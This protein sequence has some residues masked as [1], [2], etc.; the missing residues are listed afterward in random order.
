M[1]NTGTP[2][3][4]MIVEMDLNSSKFTKSL[5]QVKRSLKNSESQMKAQMAVFDSS[6][7]KLGK[8][9]S[10][11]NGLNRSL[12][13]NQ[14]H[15]DNLTKAY[16]EEVAVNGEA[17]VRAQNLA[18]D[19]NNSVA[20]QAMLEKQLKATGAAM[21]VEKLNIEELNNKMQ[22]NT[23][24]TDAAAQK[25][26]LAG[27][28]MGAL[29]TQYAGLGQK[30]NDLTRIRE[31]ERQKLEVIAQ[32]SG[33]T[34]SAYINQKA[35]LVELDN[36]I[37]TSITKM[38]NYGKQIGGLS[39]RFDNMRNSLA[40]TATKF[41]E[42]GDKAWESGKNVSMRFS[43]PLAAGIGATIKAAANFETA[44]TGVKKTVDEVVDRNGKVTYSY[45]TLETGIRQMAKEI[46]ASTTEISAVAEA[47]GQLGIQ[48][49]NVLGFT[50][51]MINMGVS[52]NMSSE[53]AAT[54][55]ARLANI[56]QMSQKDFDKLGSVIV[57]LGNNLAT[58]ESEITEMGLR[59][60]GA[61][62]QVGMSE[63]EILGLSAALSSVG[64]EAEAGGSAFSKVMVK[65]QLAVEKGV[66]AFTEL[67][68]IAN[69]AGY[70]I[71]DV[72]EAVLKGGK[73]LKSMAKSLGMS[74]KSLKSWYKEA[75]KSKTALEDF[76]TVA[77]MTGE[78]FGKLFKADPSKAII[79]FIE[80]LKDAKK[81]G[82]SAIKVLD[83]MGIT[84]V[85]LRDSLLRAANASGVF[86]G[87]VSMGNKAW[88][89]NKALTNEATKRYKTFDSQMKIFKNRIVDVAIDIG[90]PFMKAM[91]SALRSAEPVINGI[92]SM[93]KAFSDA[94]PATQKIYYHPSSDGGY[95]GT[96]YYGVRR[97]C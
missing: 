11:Y 77:G 73:P 80:G 24:L 90:G 86:S 17:S 64:I 89:E 71:G 6:G 50:K 65:M 41:K 63:G 48:T 8:L 2:L 72:S 61:G 49:P 67:E 53:T 1:A 97:C 85:R 22:A 82:T 28:K 39:P 33:K 70:T 31:A 36:E 93:S 60:A 52:T 25:Q 43:L 3:G 23:R 20:K 13:I 29:R 57:D 27:N 26:S 76:S 75:D 87:A 18:K 34:S 4:K 9:E 44:F 10:Q 68:Q 32:T 81:H 83:D 79:K 42:V 47:A 15:I 56:T 91:N 69:K 55:L 54:S 5:T 37:Q 12:Q 58:T 30:I 74:E 59:L 21:K 84:E 51:T 38:N 35:R 40:N 62:K 45:K 46:P 96:E 78:E 88:K 92:K 66:G 94:S 7:N 16:K 19:I 95:G 14:K